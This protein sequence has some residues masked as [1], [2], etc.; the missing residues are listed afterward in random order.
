MQQYL[1]C[2]FQILFSN[3]KL[4]LLCLEGRILP[5]YPIYL[6]NKLAPDAITIAAR[7]RSGASARGHPASSGPQAKLAPMQWSSAQNAAYEKTCLR[8]PRITAKSPQSAPFNGLGFG[9]RFRSRCNCQAP[10]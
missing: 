4:S 7:S 3:R 1:R 6:R 8:N 10:T 5:A 2:F 9:G